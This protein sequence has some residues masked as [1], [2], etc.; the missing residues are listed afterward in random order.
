MHARKLRHI[1]KDQHES[2]VADEIY[3]P[4]TLK[5]N[6]VVFDENSRVTCW[7]FK[8]ILSEKMISQLEKSSK[9]CKLEKAV[10]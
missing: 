10:R 3:P 8:N 4:I 7:L 5:D 2:G 6:E 1:T 9:K